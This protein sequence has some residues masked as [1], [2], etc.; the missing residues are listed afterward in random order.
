MKSVLFPTFVAR[1]HLKQSKIK[2]QHFVKVC[3]QVYLYKLWAVQ[4][5]T[6][7]YLRML[8]TFLEALRGKA[9]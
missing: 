5:K 2:Y 1:D 4:A 6:D 3:I 9:T 7:F 8:Q